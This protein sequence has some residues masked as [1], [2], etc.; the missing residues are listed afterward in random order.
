M[1]A[2]KVNSPASCNQYPINALRGSTVFRRV[3]VL[4]PN[5]RFYAIL[6]SQNRELRTQTGDPS[7]I[8]YNKNIRKQTFTWAMND[9]IRKGINTEFGL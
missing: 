7:S 8:P 6:I 4:L 3:R 5:N 1:V 2:R 9:W